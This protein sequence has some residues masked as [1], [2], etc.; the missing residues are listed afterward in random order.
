MMKD[1][2]IDD[3]VPFLGKEWSD[4]LENEMRRRMKRKTNVSR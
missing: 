1:I 2:A 3:Q 4:A